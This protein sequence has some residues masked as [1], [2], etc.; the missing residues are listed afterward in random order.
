MNQNEFIDSTI[1]NYAANLF[2]K[3][4]IFIRATCKLDRP[5]Q[6]LIYELGRSIG[7]R[8]MTISCVVFLP[9]FNLLFTLICHC[10]AV[11]IQRTNFSK[12]I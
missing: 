6:R 1:L 2:Q 11:W 8:V 12:N 4:S 10:F 7:I 5:P 9:R 3:M